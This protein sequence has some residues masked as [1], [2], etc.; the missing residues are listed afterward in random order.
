MQ[1]VM[2]PLRQALLRANVRIGLAW[3]VGCLLA[4]ALV[5][6]AALLK[7]DHD[8][9]Q[10]VDEALLDTSFRA[11]SYEEQ[12]L[13]AVAQIDQLSMSIK[14][15]W[16][17]GGAPLDLEEQFLRGVYQRDFY[18]VVINARGVAVASTRRLARGTYMGDLDFF[19]RAKAS[20]HSTLHISPPTEG[21]GGFAGKQIVRFSRSLNK[22][23]GSFDGVVLVAVEADYLAQFHD[24]GK[25]GSGDFVAVRFTDG[26]PL[27]ARA[28][29]EQPA[30]FY[31]SRPR[32]DG[33][34]GARIDPAD[35]F[36][37]RQ[38]RIVSWRR[39]EGY[40]LLAVAASG[41]AG[42]LEPYRETEQTASPRSAM[43]TAAAM[44]SA[45][46]PLSGWLSTARGKPSTCCSRC[47]TP[48]G[49]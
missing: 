22:P 14:Y 28:A 27:V 16:E 48:A 45:S 41:L 20:P 25:L 4:V 23:D 44:Q 33:D 19:L 38:S 29:G 18:P 11:K 15:Q 42:A 30:R 7:I 49:R 1:T 12:L 17:R 21:R 47:A 8:Q 6:L 31:L 32:F 46:A 39:V 34:E 3:A 24:L 40:P 37:D 5:W 2:K 10:L 26:T 9:Q 36:L 13:R 43:R 35:A